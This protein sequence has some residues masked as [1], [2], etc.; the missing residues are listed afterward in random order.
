M[1][2]QLSARPTA[3][4]LAMPVYTMQITR[5]KNSATKTCYRYTA[6]AVI[7]PYLKSVA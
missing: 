2:P 6:T 4:I 5:C 3:K 1:S 7:E